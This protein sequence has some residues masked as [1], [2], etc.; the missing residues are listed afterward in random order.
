MQ[1][2]IV[3][4]EAGGVSK[5]TTAVSLATI[6]ARLGLTTLLV[7]LDPRAAA[8][9]WIGVEPNEKWKTVSAIIAEPDPEGWATELALPTPWSDNLNLLPSDRSL[10]NREREQAD[11]SEVR[12]TTALEGVDE[13]L[14]IIDCPNR[15]GGTLT[16]NALAAAH[17]VVYAASATQDGVDGV[18]GARESVQ[19]FR[20]SRE[21]IGA[22]ARI[23]ELGIIA[24]AVTDTVLPR[25]ARAALDDLGDSGLLLTPVVPRRTIVDQARMTST[26]YGDFPKGAP[27][28]R[29]YETLLPQII[30]TT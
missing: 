9:K 18:A 1:T 5:T 10:A 24:G 15:Q 7:D 6:A 16:Q 13:T 23:T 20:R 26:W 25:V 2:I 29:A 19:R 30:S 8:T 17:G 22:P 27:V 12:L 3:Y 21:R 4:S 14:V 11:H 28:V